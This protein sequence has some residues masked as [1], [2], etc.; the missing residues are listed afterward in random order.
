MSEQKDKTNSGII[1]GRGGRS[2]S[3][4]SVA[5][6]SGGFNSLSRAKQTPLKTS[7]KDSSKIDSSITNVFTEL[8]PEQQASILG[9]KLD[10]LFNLP[11]DYQAASVH[12]L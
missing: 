12:F 5:S 1:I 3:S 11:N 9:N 2:N 4:Y 8:D 6:N 7:L 10:T